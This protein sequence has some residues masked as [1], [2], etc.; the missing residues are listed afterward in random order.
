MKNVDAGLLSA[1]MMGERKGIQ[2]WLD[3][4]ASLH[5][6][7]KRGQTALM[8]CSNIET[9]GWLISEGVPIDAR[10]LGGYTALFEAAER[11]NQQ[12][13]RLLL[14]NGADVNARSN[15]GSTALFN[16][17]TWHKPQIVRLLLDYGADA[18]ARCNDGSTPL[19]HAAWPW[20]FDTEAVETL[21]LLL[22]HGADVN[23]VDQQ[24]KTA[25]I[26]LL[27][28]DQHDGERETITT[29]PQR[30]AAYEEI[31]RLLL[32]YNAETGIVDSDGNTAL[33][34]SVR[35]GLNDVVKLLKQQAQ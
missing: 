2:R 11:Q 3:R 31:V 26:H 22:S 23:A 8:L 18:N 14:D 1:V 28:D 21:S 6:V 32:A 13:V 30:E 27:E 29:F 15:W 34:F 25:L 10:D 4:G 33:S 24:G 35:R 5:A 12:L 16:A 20:P 19:M 17:A 9:L 7:N